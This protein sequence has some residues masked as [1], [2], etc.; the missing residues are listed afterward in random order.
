MQKNYY[1]KENLPYIFISLSVIIM[2]IWEHTVAEFVSPVY[3]NIINNIWLISINLILSIMLTIYNV[4][5]FLQI[6]NIKKIKDLSIFQIVKYSILWLGW[7]LAFLFILFPIFEE[8]VVSISNR[9][10]GIQDEIIINCQINDKS[11]DEKNNYIRLKYENEILRIK[12]NRD[13]YNKLI[14]GDKFDLKVKKGYWG[15]FYK[16]K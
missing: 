12:V 2:M 8:S 13:E 10:V 14:I 7:C 4:K 16:D 11:N 5:L 9:F 6:R 3:N 1:W 15:L